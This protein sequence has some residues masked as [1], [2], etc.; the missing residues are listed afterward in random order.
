M[1]APSASGGGGG[2]RTLAAVSVTPSGSGTRVPAAPVAPTSIPVAHGIVLALASGKAGHGPRHGPP[3]LVIPQSHGD[4][5]TGLDTSGGVTAAHVS[6]AWVQLHAQGDSPRRSPIKL[7]R[8]PLQPRPALVHTP[9][10]AQGFVAVAAGRMVAAAPATTPRAVTPRLLGLVPSAQVE[11]A[12]RAGAAHG[13]AGPRA[14]SDHAMGFAPSGSQT[15]RASQRRHRRA[16]PT[17]PRAAAH[18]GTTAAP[19][20]SPPPPS[21]SRMVCAFRRRFTALPATARVRDCRCLCPHDHF[22]AKQGCGDNCG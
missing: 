3:A 21:Q 11:H 12:G 15:S 19:K 18:K 22:S 7:D 5:D 14:R 1:N 8:L 16:S 10:T 4:E 6:A 9:A 13:V 2:S 17:S 20:T